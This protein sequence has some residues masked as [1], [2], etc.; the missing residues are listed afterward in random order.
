MRAWGSVALCAALTASFAA[1]GCGHTPDPNDILNQY[2]TDWSKQDFQGMYG[3]LSATAKKQISEKDFVTRY[4]DIESGI[5]TQ[6]IVVQPPASDDNV[7]G[8]TAKLGFRVTWKTA[9]TNPFTKTYTAQMVKDQDGWRIDWQPNLIFPALKPGWKVRAQVDE[10]ARGSILSADGQ[11]LATNAPG[12]EI[13]LVPGKMTANSVKDLAAVLHLSASD[14]QTSLHQSWVK[15]DLFV[16][17]KTLPAQTEQSLEPQLL[18]IPGVLITDSPTPVRTYPEG[19]AAAHVVGYLG[20]ITAQELTAARKSEGYSSTDVIGQAGL[21]AA[22]ET[23]LRG[24]PGGKIWLVNGKGQSESVIAQRQA[25]PG[26]TVTV[27]LNSKVQAALASALGHHIGSAVALD[28][29]TGAVLGM[30]SSPG[31]DPDA[32]TQGLSSAAWQ[33]LLSNTQAPLVNRALSPIPPGSALKPLVAAIGLTDGVLKPST[34]FPSDAEHWQKDASWGNYYVTR[35]PHP[36]GTADLLHALVWSDNVYFAQ[37]GLAIGAER[38]VQGLDRFG[39]GKSLSFPLAV[40]KA[41]VSSTGKIQSDIQLADSAYGQGQVLVSPLQLADM[42]TAFLNDGNVLSPYL[43]S[44]ETSAFGKVVLQHPARTVA[45]S[46]GVSTDAVQVV[47]AD[48]RQV[49]A[50]PAGTAHGIADIPGWTISGKTG[51]A[52]SKGTDWGWF[53]SWGTPSGQ[54]KPTILVAMALANTQNVGGSKF[55]VQQVRNIYEQLR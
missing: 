6:S 41:Q 52:Q 49:V 36:A 29:S 25:T 9:I 12:K 22:L 1:A 55:T 17:V 19:T 33:A 24:T 27:T 7:S 43:V 3:L 20:P 51:T 34:T 28:P 35:E 4:Q 53:V 16:P 37:A 40:G 8:G 46:T 15:P 26:D 30:A 13:G 44:K 50:D 54:S 11:L 48:L 47:D 10:P 32:L 31:Y 14:I 5:E 21:E 45:E 2:L 18:K 39:F 38:F 23:Q 42:Y